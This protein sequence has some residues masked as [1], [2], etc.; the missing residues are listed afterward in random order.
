[1]G[2]SFF[3]NPGWGA[4]RSLLRC[5]GSLEFHPG[6]MMGKQRAFHPL[7]QD[8]GL[9]TTT[10]GIQ[11]RPQ[12]AA[13]MTTF[14]RLRGSSRESGACRHV[15]DRTGDQSWQQGMFQERRTFVALRPESR[16]LATQPSSHIHAYAAG[17]TH[18]ITKP[19]G[20]SLRPR[21]RGSVGCSRTPSAFRTRVDRQAAEAITHLTQREHGLT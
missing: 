13:Y 16:D 12:L 19:R 10:C 6:H 9:L 3:Q 2:K 17:R 15:S 18:A 20:W 4:G 14:E 21:E 1:V 8:A 11:H 7:A 5:F